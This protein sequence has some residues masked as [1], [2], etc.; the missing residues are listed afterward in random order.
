MQRKWWWAGCAATVALA[1][2]GVWHLHPAGG[3][4]AGPPPLP[5]PVITAESPQAQPVRMI[6]TLP[7][8]LPYKI[9][10]KK[11]SL[12]ALVEQLGMRNDTRLE[13]PPYDKANKAF[14]YRNSSTPGEPG[15]AVFLG[16]VDSKDKIAAFFY[17]SRIRPGNQ[18]E[19]IREDRSTAIFEVSSVEQFSKSNFPTERVYGYTEEPT[20]RLVTCGGKYDTKTQSYVDNIVVFATMV[21]SLPSPPV[22]R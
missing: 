22:K 8:S 9:V 21:S 12:W 13:T 18:I 14:W 17:L 19:V 7:R 1:G 4:S 16:H 15:P 10:V 6:Q 11:I 3:L 5:A 2:W 20:L